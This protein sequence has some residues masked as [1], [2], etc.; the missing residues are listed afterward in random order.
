MYCIVKYNVGVAGTIASFVMDEG[1]VNMV[2][3]VTD[4]TYPN[5]V[6]SW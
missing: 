3:V 1:T 4:L 2:P 5:M 6:V